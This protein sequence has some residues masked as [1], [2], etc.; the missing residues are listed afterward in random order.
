MVVSEYLETLGI[1]VKNCIRISLVMTVIVR[2]IVKN[3]YK[4]ANIK[5]TEYT[6]IDQ[7]EFMY[8]TRTYV[9]SKQCP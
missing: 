6:G 2:I 9:T 8:A 4:Q 5:H 1:V 3:K 7:D